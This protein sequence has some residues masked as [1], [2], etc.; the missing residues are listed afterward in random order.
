MSDYSYV[1]LQLNRL[2]P[3]VKKIV[4]SPYGPAVRVIDSGFDP[5][6][7]TGELVYNVSPYLLIWSAA[8]CRSLLAP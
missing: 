3:S 1:K 7:D 4:K 2:T 5:E 8:S 6:R